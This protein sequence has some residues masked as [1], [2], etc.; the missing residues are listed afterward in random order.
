MPEDASKKSFCAAGRTEAAK[1]D[2]WETA[3]Q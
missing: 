3:Q 2:L 1:A